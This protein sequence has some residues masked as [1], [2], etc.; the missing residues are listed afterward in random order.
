MAKKKA[1]KKGKVTASAVTMAG[2]LTFAGKPMA[3]AIED[4][5]AAA[6]YACLKKGIID[7]DKIREA[8]LKAREE[9]KAAAA[10]G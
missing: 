8:K 7:P 1:T 5:M 2:S 9:V 6:H 10:A 3:K 4:A